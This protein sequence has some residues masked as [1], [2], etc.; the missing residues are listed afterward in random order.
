MVNFCF[1]AAYYYTFKTAGGVVIGY[2]NSSE[3]FRSGGGKTFKEE[4]TKP[5]INY[6]IDGIDYSESLKKWGGLNLPGINEKVILLYKEDKY[7][8]ELYRFFQYWLTLTDVFIIF[9]GSA[10]LNIV[11]ETLKF[12]IKKS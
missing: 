9:F 8:P 3:T 11:Y 7:N 4:I 12:Y 5:I 10:F 1:K 6:T 2:Y